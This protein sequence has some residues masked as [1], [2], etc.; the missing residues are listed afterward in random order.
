MRPISRNEYPLARRRRTSCSIFG[1]RCR[2]IYALPVSS[3]ND[4]WLTE[5]LRGPFESTVF[6]LPLTAG[7]VRVAQ[8]ESVEFLIRMSRPAAAGALRARMGASE[9]PRAAA[10]CRVVPRAAASE[11]R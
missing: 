7:S 5:K 10:C 8:G 1:D 2:G 3:S 11:K 6:R 4:G 9:L